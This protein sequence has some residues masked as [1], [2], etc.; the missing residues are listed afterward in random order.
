[1]DQELMAKALQSVLGAGYE[2][3]S[4]VVT[5]SHSRT[6]SPHDVLQ[7]RVAK[8]G[9]T[10]GDLHVPTTLGAD[11]PKKRAKLKPVEYVAKGE[12]KDK[13][14]RGLVTAGAAGGV[15]SLPS[16][17]RHTEN[18]L[19]RGGVLKPK[20]TAVPKTPGRVKGA[21]KPAIHV[22]EEH[23]KAGAGL[24][25]GAAGLE[26]AG[27][28]GDFVAHDALGDK[29]KPKRKTAVLKRLDPTPAEETITFSKVDDDKRQVFGWCSISKKDG[30]DVV[31]LQGDHIPIEEVEKSAYSYMLTSRKGGNQHARIT[32]NFGLAERA[33]GDEPLHVGDCIESMVF[34]PEKIEKMGL[35]ATFPQGWWFGMQI[36]DEETWG[37]IKRGER[38][39]FSIH[40]KG[41]R[42][43]LVAKAKATTVTHVVVPDRKEQAKDIALGVAGST[44]AGA[45]AGGALIPLAAK[46]GLME[47][48]KAERVGGRLKTIGSIVGGTAGVYGGL[49]AAHQAAK[50]PKLRA[51]PASAKAK[52]TERVGVKKAWTPTVDAPSPEA[53]RA[54]RAKHY[55]TGATLGAVATIPAAGHQLRQGR[56]ALGRQVGTTTVKMHQGRAQARVADE[57]ARGIQADVNRHQAKMARAKPAQRGGFVAGHNKRVAGIKAKAVVDREAALF[58]I[59]HKAKA[60]NLR[61][62]ESAAMHSR[63]AGKIG[64]LG[65]GLAGAAGAISRK[66][67]GSWRP[68]PGVK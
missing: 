36:H 28:A 9:P 55:Q 54:R 14:A 17:K 37:Q 60:H 33:R 34:T 47:A 24:A 35:P 3:Q 18:E 30:V 25:A 58:N 39:G 11:K 32:K 22:L 57:A 67:K 51:I 2:S 31:D 19:R 40:G 66:R 20:A 61:A 16:L 4:R 49:H 44:A 59:E 64:L 56:K 50:N 38:A 23:P 48:T 43:E 15:L 45:G 10:G 29:E 12:R 53:R 46:K 8:S 21:L 27:L 52:V 13:V 63:R 42:E 65:A 6:P 7:G 5:G 1:M 26:L 68:Y 62:V 41:R